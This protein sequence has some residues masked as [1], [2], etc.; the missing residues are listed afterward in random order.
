M[1]SHHHAAQVHHAH[2]TSSINE[3]EEDHVPTQIGK[4]SLFFSLY[5]RWHFLHLLLPW[6]MM[7]ASRGSE[8]VALPDYLL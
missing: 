2:S 1:A 8:I 3:E 7:G 6:V 5:I 4:V